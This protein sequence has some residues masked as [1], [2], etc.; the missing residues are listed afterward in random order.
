MRPDIRIPSRIAALPRD[1]R[2]YPVPWFVAWV[3]GKP[4]FRVIAAGKI[5]RAIKDRRCWVCGE[6]TG[7]F[8]A[9]TIGP[10]CAINRVSSEPPSHQECAEFSARACPF[11]SNPAAPRRETLLPADRKDAAGYGIKRNP[12]VALVWTTQ[13]YKVFPAPGGVLIEVGPPN[14]VK[15]FCEG[16]EATRAEVEASIE[17]GLPLLRAP[18]EQ[19]GKEAVAEL[20]RRYAAA[21]ALLPRADASA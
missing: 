21:M 8:L 16:R 12:G 19:E 13:S 10:M 15:W 7:R 14:S 3:D 6:Q 20:E 17:S 11:L 18:A 2:G 4:D 9:F 1:Q 5:A